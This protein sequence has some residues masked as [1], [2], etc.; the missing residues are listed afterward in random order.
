MGKETSRH[1]FRFSG[2]HVE[3]MGSFGWTDGNCTDEQV[4]HSV[5]SCMGNTLL[6]VNYLTRATLPRE[7]AEKCAILQ[8]FTQ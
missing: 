4:H 1:R 8:L 7:N 6:Y 5:V 2:F 3:I